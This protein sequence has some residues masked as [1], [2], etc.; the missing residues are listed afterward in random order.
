M[1]GEPIM[2]NPT[3]IADAP[4]PAAADRALLLNAPAVAAA[5]GV[6]VATVYRWGAAGRIPAPVKIG[7]ATRW[8]RSELEEW[9]RARCPGR[10]KWE[11]LRA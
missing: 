2:H 7:G 3:K 8:S 6:N 11:A 1:E 4:N 9:I 10:E 5:L